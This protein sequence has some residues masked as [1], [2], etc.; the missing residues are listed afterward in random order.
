MLQNGKT[1]FEKNNHPIESLIEEKTYLNLIQ[2][3]TTRYLNKEVTEEESFFFKFLNNALSCPNN[4][5]IQ[6]QDIVNIYMEE[7]Y[8]YLEYIEM[9][10]EDKKSKRSKIKLNGKD[11]HDIKR[12]ILFKIDIYNF[13]EI[14]EIFQKYCSEVLFF[15]E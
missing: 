5:I 14:N 9:E 12:D 2:T 1:N 13:K 10:L 7:G 4:K 11:I 15:T 8:L 3:S 6:Y